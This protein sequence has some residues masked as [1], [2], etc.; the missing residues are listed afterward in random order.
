MEL[1]TGSGLALA[2][3]LNAYVPMLMI[4]LLSRY[5]TLVSL[6][7]E[8]AWITNGWVLVVLGVLLA[9]E[10]VA[11]KVPAVDHVN[12]ILQ[13]VVRPTAGGIVFAAGSGAVTPATTDPGE[14]LTSAAV[15]PFACGVVLA[16]ITHIGKAGVRA[17]VNLSTAGVGAPV[18]STVEDITAVALTIVALLLP[19]LVLVLVTAA[20]VVVWRL[21]RRRTRAA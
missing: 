1:L 6:P 10:V 21:Q 19:V 17:G 9:V 7:P 16:L 2:S 14:F 11:D 13:T 3:G 12:D 20:A 18:A 8:W 15:L 5:T 4:G